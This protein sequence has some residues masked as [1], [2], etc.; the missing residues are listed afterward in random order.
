MIP[1]VGVAEAGRTLAN[2]LGSHIAVG[3]GGT[4]PA[5]ADQNLQFEIWRGDITARAFDPDT[6]T[7]HFKTTIPAVLDMTVVE[8]ALIASD[9][10]EIYSSLISAADADSETWAGGTWTATG[11]RMGD[12]GINLVAATATMTGVQV[13]L[14]SFGPRDFIQMAYYAATGGGTGTLTLY[15]T[16][17]SYY[18]GTF[19]VAAG[20]NVVGFK[21]EDLVATNSP[22]LSNIE[23]ITVAHSGAGSLT[24]DAIRAVRSEVNSTLVQRSVITPTVKRPGV[25]MDIEVSL[26]V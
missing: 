1:T 8:T 15:T 10:N 25:P 20:Y 13:N 2:Y 12:A 5:L 16:D 23:K 6:R 9:S 18:R 11:V 7:V 19:T 17:T 21:V 4:A 3:I 14:S 22:D 24:L 26:V